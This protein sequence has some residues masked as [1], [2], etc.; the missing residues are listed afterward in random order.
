MDLYSFKKGRRIPLRIIARRRKLQLSRADKKYN[1][2]K[3][4]TKPAI[5]QGEYIVAPEKL[6]LYEVSV[7]EKIFLDTLEFIKNIRENFCHKKTVIDFR[8]TRRITAAALVIIYATLHD[9]LKLG[10]QKSAVM[11]PTDSA[12]STKLIRSKNVHKLIKGQNPDVDIKSARTLPI[13]SGVGNEHFDDVIDYIQKRIFNDKMTEEDE[14]VYSDAVS[15]TINN[16]GLH[17]YP[18]LSKPDRRWWMTCSVIGNQLFLAIYDLGVGIPET[19]MRKDWFMASLKS[20]Y[21]EVYKKLHDEIPEV[22]NGTLELFAYLPAK[23]V[24][25]DSQMIYLAMTGDV[26]GTKQTKHGQGSKSIKA[27]VKE[28]KNGKLWAFSGKGLYTLGHE[29][30]SKDSQSASIPDDANRETVPQLYTLPTA[31]PGTLIQW[32]IQLS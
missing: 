27:L 15:E 13:I 26:S 11:Y 24:V 7:D 21:P 25:K 20:S 32:N 8:Q 4:P 19:V 3:Y 22:R 29:V 31:I 2:S 5:L 14:Y 28:T 12:E 6:S 23:L 16:V 30:K 1:P 10:Y 9:N 17:A 18:H